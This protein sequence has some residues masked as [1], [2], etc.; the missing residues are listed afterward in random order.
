MLYSEMMGLDVYTLLVPEFL[1]AQLPFGFCQKEALL[2][3]W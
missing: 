1:D 2:K 3:G